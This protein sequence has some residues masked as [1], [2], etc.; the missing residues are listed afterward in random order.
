M[1]RYITLTNSADTIYGRRKATIKNK[2]QAGPV[3]LTVVTI[4]ILGLVSLFYLAQMFYT[5]TVGYDIA[6]L[7]TQREELLES[8]EKLEL[9]VADMKSY[10]TIKEEAT[11][12]NMVPTKD[13]VMLT[14]TSSTF[15]V[16]NR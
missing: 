2:I 4:V 8:N 11:K 13:S 12:L 7:E 1:G 9:Q 15:A 3:S 5:T 6:D 10:K 14:K 16:A